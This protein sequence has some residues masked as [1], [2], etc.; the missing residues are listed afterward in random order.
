MPL[1]CGVMAPKIE[2]SAFLVDERNGTV[3]STYMN[4]SKSAEEQT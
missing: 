4:D 3:L 2:D 1:G